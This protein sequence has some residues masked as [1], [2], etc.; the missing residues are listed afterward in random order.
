MIIAAFVFG[1]LCQAQI[2]CERLRKSFSGLL[3]I[4]VALII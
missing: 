1:F 2:L 4:W 3:A